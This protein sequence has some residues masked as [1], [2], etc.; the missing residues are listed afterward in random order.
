LIRTISS[1]AQAIAEN[2]DSIYPN[3]RMDG[4]VPAS[5]IRSD[6]ID[7]AKSI[8]RDTGRRTSVL[9]IVSGGIRERLYE[10]IAGRPFDS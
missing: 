2:G 10:A 5:E 4:E 6:T 9:E 1:A 3:L 7:C 8:V